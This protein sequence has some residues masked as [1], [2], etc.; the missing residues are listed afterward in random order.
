M[1][2]LFLSFKQ[3]QI[4]EKL[5]QDTKINSFFPLEAVSTGLNVA[6][7]SMSVRFLWQFQTQHSPALPSG[8]NLF[9][10]HFLARPWVTLLFL[11]FIFLESFSIFQSQIRTSLA[12]FPFRARCRVGM[13]FLKWKKSKKIAHERRLIRGHRLM[14]GELK[15]CTGVEWL[16]KRATQ[17][18]IKSKPW[19]IIRAWE[20]WWG[21]G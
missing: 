9:P 15:L 1:V 20:I 16:L 21:R 10:R 11:L 7:I 14:H 19:V 5:Q 17:I 4:W 8:S 2:F 3:T 6:F 12:D 18:V 13:E